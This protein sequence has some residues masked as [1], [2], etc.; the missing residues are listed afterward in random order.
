ME[1]FFN[2][3]R[4]A[5]IGV[6]PR[7]GNLGQ[8]I[9]R[10]LL[11]YQFKGEIIPIGPRGGVVQ[12]FAINTSLR[13][14]Q[15]KI[16]LAVILTP[17]KTIP[18]ILEQ[19]GQARIKRVV[20]ESGGFGEF[21]SRGKILSDKL[22][23][24][25][26]KHKIR[27]IGPNG[28]GIVNRHTGLSVPF[29]SL[30]K[31]S[32]GGISI[33]TQSGGVGVTYC[34]EFVSEHLG[35]AKF[36]SIGNK[37]DVNE[38]DL[39]EYFSRDDKTKMILTYLESIKDGRKL[40][41]VARKCKKPLV[42][43]KANIGK[44]S[45]SIAAG[46][47]SAIMTD[48]KAVKAMFFQAGIIR[49][50]SRWQSIAAS[51]IFTLPP[52]KGNRIAIMS[53]S[54]GHAVVAADVCHIHG[55]TLPQFPKSTLDEIES[56]VRARVIKMQNPLDL[57]DL[58][59][60]EVYQI[61]IEK[62]IAQKDIDGVLFLFMYYSGYDPQ[63]PERIVDFL[64]HLSKK[65]KKPIALVLDSWAGEVR[66][67][68]EYSHFP[69]FNSPD[70]AAWALA[71]SRDHIDGIKRKSHKPVRPKG[72]KKDQIK[73]MIRGFVRTGR[74][75]RMTL[76]AKSF[77]LL[78][79]YGIP[80]PKRKVVKSTKEAVQFSGKIGFPVV[81]KIESA[82]ITH[83]SDQG[84]VALNIKSVS[85]LKKII[86]GWKK[87]FGN[88][89]DGIFISPMAD[90]GPEL[91]VGAKRDDLFGPMIMVGWGG[92]F[93]EMF[94]EPVIRLAPVSLNQAMEMVKELPNQNILEGFRG[95]L[96]VSKKAVAQA[97][98]RIGWMIWDNREIS[99]IDV[100]PFRA[101]EK[102]A[103]ALDGRIFLDLTSFA[104]SNMEK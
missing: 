69:I 36:A 13:K 68:K 45:Q 65:H 62:V 2:A 5:V 90:D 61:I 60:M 18:S 100:N 20:I 63:V 54:G 97:L 93:A 39:I 25:A 99:E 44:T 87:I 84:G 34:N 59:D 71:L 58:F 46:H 77:D 72:I 73:K 21:D 19:C 29:A 66:R 26:K 78:R 53:R 7:P 31:P 49:S 70:E 102:G 4:V 98:V 28:I 38:S 91:I 1:Q 47:S 10:N 14:V 56:H 15:G 33:I 92:V 101:Y 12:G 50:K 75:P 37:I 96:K 43:H 16:D 81:A 82:V 42:I 83:K 79:G 55:L 24:I 86:R 27:I 95:G 6:S 52:M 22:V 94:D 80:C 51:K 67:M 88:K 35:L 32:S 23:A 30:P 57:G 41:Q 104:K 89:L 11:N 48:E 3:T 40:F 85:E 76:N 9:I 8:R 17:A 74:G 103:L 64:S